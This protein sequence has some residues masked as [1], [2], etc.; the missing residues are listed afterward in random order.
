MKGNHFTPFIDKPRTRSSS[1]DELC[2]LL[3]EAHFWRSRAVELAFACPIVFALGFAIAL[4][5]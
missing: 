5:V 1:M 4:G 2:A 3:A